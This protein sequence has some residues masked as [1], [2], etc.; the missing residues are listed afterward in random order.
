MPSAPTSDSPSVD[1]DF[2]KHVYGIKQKRIAWNEKYYVRDEN[3][4]DVLFAVRDLKFFKALGAGL[5]AVIVYGLVLGVFV[6][7]AASTAGAAE[8]YTGT[9]VSSAPETSTGTA[10]ARKNNR[11]NVPATSTVPESAPV[12]T[13]TGI[14][15]G[16]FVPVSHTTAVKPAGTKT[17]AEIAKENEEAMKRLEETMK[18]F[19][20]KTS[21]GV[22]VKSKRATDTVES[23]LIEIGS[24]LALLLAVLTGMALYPKRHIRF[25]RNDNDTKSAPV[26]SIVQTRRFE[27][28]HQKYRMEDSAGNLMA[29]FEKNVFTNVFRRRWWIILPDGRKFLIKEDSIILSLF[30]RLVPVIGQFIRTNFVFFDLRNDPNQ[31]RPIGIFKRKFELFDNYLLD[32]K[33]DPAFTIPRKVA[34]GLSVL[35]DTGEKR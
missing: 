18:T 24:Y 9:T 21:S 27:F 28:P 10:P 35:L 11:R 20:T 19:N 12:M 6:M 7:A 14:P 23:P 32:L 26:F 29:T 4:A 17:A 25:Y 16:T 33:D 2:G 31:T 15:T 13:S 30:R 34:I 1:K 22:A 8:A 3:N 5:V